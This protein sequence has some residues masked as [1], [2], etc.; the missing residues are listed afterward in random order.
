MLKGTVFATIGLLL[1]LLNP[2]FISRL[3][4]WIDED[5]PV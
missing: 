3:I 5:D 1:E 4:D 2:F